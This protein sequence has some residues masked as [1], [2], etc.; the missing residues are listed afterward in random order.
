MGLPLR[1]HKKKGD[2]LAVTGRIH[3]S[4]WKDADGTERY[5]TEIIAENVM[6]I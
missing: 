6:F 3:Y 4:R 1:E 5:G 2:Q